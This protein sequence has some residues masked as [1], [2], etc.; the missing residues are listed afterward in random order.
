MNCFVC[1]NKIGLL[2]DKGFTQDHKFICYEDINKLFNTDKAHKH[3]IP[4]DL[5]KEINQI[6]SSAITKVLSQDKINQLFCPNCGSS[7]VQPLGQHHKNFSAGKAIGGAI[8]TG[9]V[10]TIAGFLG[11]NTKQT[12]FVCMD[13]GKQFKK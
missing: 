6:S 11:K 10:G 9:G 5:K 1:G 3:I 12:D 8:L 13:C 2:D 4:T 7:N